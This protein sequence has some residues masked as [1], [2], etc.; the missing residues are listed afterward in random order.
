MS[1][2]FRQLMKTSKIF[3][4]GIKQLYLDLNDH[5][6]FFYFFRPLKGLKS[7]VVQEDVLGLLST[8]QIFPA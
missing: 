4:S 7:K 1:E 8:Q 5:F 6:H 2:L 3:W